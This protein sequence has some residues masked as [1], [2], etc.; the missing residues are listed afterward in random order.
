MSETENAE[1]RSM[2]GRKPEGNQST[3]VRLPPDIMK[4]I[5]EIA[6][7]GRRAQWIREALEAVLRFEE[8]F[9]RHRDKP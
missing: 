4:K 6:G 8:L 3:N 9:K 2:A 1:T 7:P 5:D